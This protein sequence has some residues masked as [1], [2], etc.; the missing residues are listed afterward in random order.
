[1]LKLSNDEYINNPPQSLIT[2]FYTWKVTTVIYPHTFESSKQ[3][4]WLNPI[5]YNSTALYFL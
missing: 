1:M 5:P 2:D 4:T 3:A